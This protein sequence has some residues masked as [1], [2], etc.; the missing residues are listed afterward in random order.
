MGIKLD[1][2]P[3]AVQQDNYLIKIINVY[4]AY[5]LRAWLKDPTNK[6]KFRNYLFGKTNIVKNIDKKQYLYSGYR[7]IFDTVDSWSFG[8]DYARNVMIFGV[9]NNSLSHSDNCKNNVSILGEGPIFGINGSF[10]SQEKQ[11]GI[12]FNKEISF[13][14]SILFQFV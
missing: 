6:F 10:G 2:D 13:V 11:F 1:N 4:I 8:N 5:D 3:L 12:Y 7:I 14:L 9:D